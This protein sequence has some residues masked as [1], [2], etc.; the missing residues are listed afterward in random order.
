MVT[1]ADNYALLN[2]AL[3][4]NFVNPINQGMAAQT[5]LVLQQKQRDDALALQYAHEQYQR[6]NQ[7]A[8]IHAAQQFQVQQQVAQHLHA[9]DAQHQQNLFAMAQQDS[10]QRHADASQQSSQDFSKQQAMTA[11]E[12]ALA[13]GKMAE[14]AT[15]LLP[16]LKESPEGLAAWASAK[17]AKESMAVLQKYVPKN[18]LDKFNADHAMNEANRVSI[19][20]QAVKS[21]FEGVNADIKLKA[22]KLALQDPVHRA[23][24]E[25]LGVPPK[26]VED[27]VSGNSS[28]EQ[29]QQELTAAEQKNTSWYGS[30]IP[31]RQNAAEAHQKFSQAVAQNVIELDP[32]GTLKNDAELAGLMQTLGTSTAK[33]NGYLE[34][35][36]DQP[37][38]MRDVL[39]AAHPGLKLPPVPS[40]ATNVEYGERG[41]RQNAPSAS[42]TQ[43]T[44]NNI[45]ALIAN[46]S[47]APA[48]DAKFGASGFSAAKIL[49]AGPT[50]TNSGSVNF[51]GANTFGSQL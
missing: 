47:L 34:N 25:R 40:K 3:Q 37:Q 17:N 44:Q 16:A 10:S 42:L 4:Q 29:F 26:A 32:T 22:V 5:A 43:P 49:Q 27:F 7:L 18:T 1:A 20:E 12:N 41:T 46:P 2:Q 50:I 45:N 28:F 19:A 15:E 11:D 8:D 38:V 24:V 13:H 39:T 35:V 33:M 23:E 6:T 30:H 14:M 21:R 51:S 9:I 31:F 36:V 48:F